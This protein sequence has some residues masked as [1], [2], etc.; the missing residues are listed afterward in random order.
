MHD[1]DKPTPSLP[2]V[3]NPSATTPQISSTGLF[4]PYKLNKKQQQQSKNTSA[5]TTK[6]LVE[7]NKNDSDAEDDDDGTDFLGL[8]KP[9]QIQVTNTDIESVL[10]ETFPKPRPTVVEQPPV[11]NVPQYFQD[12]DEP[13]PTDNQLNNDD[14]DEEVRNFK[15]CSLFLLFK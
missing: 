6:S 12:L 13:E 9:N 10:R 2:V 15:T 7:D 1:E 4:I 8:S 14:D 3:K 11:Q 5:T